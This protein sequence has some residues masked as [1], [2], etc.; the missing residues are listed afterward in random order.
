MRVKFLRLLAF[1]M[2][3]CTPLLAVE[4]R[5]PETKEDEQEILDQYLL[6][7]GE[8]KETLNNLFV[9]YKLMD[10]FRGGTGTKTKEAFR[11]A[12]FKFLKGTRITEHPSM[13]GYVVKLG[14]ANRVHQHVSR[15]WMAEA[16]R[17]VIAEHGLEHVTIPEKYLYHLP[18]RPTELVDDNYAVISEKVECSS[19][20]HNRTKLRQLPIET[21]K[22]ILTIIEEVVY[23]DPSPSN[24]RV[25]GDGETVAII[26]TEKIHWKR[27][28]D[29]ARCVKQFMTYLGANQKSA[30]AKK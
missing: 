24:I 22:E 20:R 16:V 1:M 18:G 7:D 2:A 23:N 6:P 21:V 9:T 11:R 27:N 8:L 29:I 28:W 12:G 3:I 15:I 30:L 4:I 10:N 17:T 14:R 25:L 26:D 5:W 19:D 13:P